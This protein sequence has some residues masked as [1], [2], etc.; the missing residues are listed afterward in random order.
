MRRQGFPIQLAM[1]CLALLISS[2]L[3]GGLRG[4]QQPASSQAPKIAVDVK[5]VNVLAT[6]RDKQRAIVS[7]LGMDDFV[8]TED[9]KPQ[10]ITYFLRETVV[11]LTLGLLVDTS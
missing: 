2:A 9:G 5:V 7:N 10:Q 6:V 8:L 4:Q 3:S 1:F 11:P